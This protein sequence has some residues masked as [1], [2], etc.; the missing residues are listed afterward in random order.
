MKKYSVVYTIDNSYVCHCLVSI[1]SLVKNN[2]D[3]D[4]KIY[5]ISNLLTDK[6]I[7]KI[8]L[9]KLKHKLDLEYI[10]INEKHFVGLVVNHHF[11]ISNYFRLLIPKVISEDIVLYLDSDTIINGSIVEIFNI[12]LKTKY[13][14]AVVDPYFYSHQELNMSSESKYFNSGVMLLNNKAFREDEIAERT[15]EFIQ[16]NPRVIKF[17]DQ[18]GLNSVINGRWASIHPKYNQQTIFF[19]NSFDKLSAYFSVKEIIDSKINPIIIHYTGSSKPWHLSNQHPF[20]NLYWKYRNQTIFKS[21]FSDD[22]SVKII[23]RYILRHCLSKHKSFISFLKSTF[24]ICIF[25]VF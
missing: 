10:F 13:L 22:L 23:S 7:K 18:C 14:A 11:S 1:Y 4:L 12:E 3:I 5:L 25:M 8:D 17:V 24:L 9:F 6:N 16:K 15:I 19:D 20:K 2:L 21:Y